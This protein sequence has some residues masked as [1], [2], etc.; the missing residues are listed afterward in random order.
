MPLDV[1]GQLAQYVTSV[2]NASMRAFWA[3]SPLL[4]AA[5]TASSDARPFAALSI[6]RLE[7]A[8][9]AEK[10]AIM[11]LRLARAMPTGPPVATS[12]PS[13]ASLPAPA[14]TAP[15]IPLAAPSMTDS[16]EAALAKPSGIR[17]AALPTDSSSAAA[18]LPPVAEML[19][20]MV[21]PACRAIDLRQLVLY[22]SQRLQP[23]RVL[24]QFPA[25]ERQ[26]ATLAEP[27]HV[28]E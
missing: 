3:S 24:I 17:A 9:N 27:L 25:R 1:V 10:P 23:S 15:P 13:W 21:P 6:S 26:H 19:R 11:A 18:C 12:E 2:R 16:A 28:V 5:T 22:D 8:I 14:A 20:A 7:M 4:R